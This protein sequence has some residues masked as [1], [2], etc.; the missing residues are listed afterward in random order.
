MLEDNIGN[1][2]FWKCY[3]SIFIIC[4][5]KPIIINIKSNVTPVLYF[6]KII[7]NDYKL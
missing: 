4:K 6:L 5:N 1:M 2:V 7:F 3:L